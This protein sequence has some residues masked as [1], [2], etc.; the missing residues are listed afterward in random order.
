MNQNNEHELQE[1]PH[2]LARID[3]KEQRIAKLTAE[4]ERLKTAIDTAVNL[5]PGLEAIFAEALNETP[6]LDYGREA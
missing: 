3:W 2:L 5:Y 1:I 6:V 4:N